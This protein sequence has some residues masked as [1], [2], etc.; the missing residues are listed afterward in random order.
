M[1]SVIT[2][3]RNFAMLLESSTKSF[4]NQHCT[5]SE[6]GKPEFCNFRA[7]LYATMRI[8]VV[9]GWKLTCDRKI[10]FPAFSSAQLHPMINEHELVEGSRELATVLWKYLLCKRHS[11]W[12]VSCE[13]SCGHDFTHCCDRL[14]P[15]AVAIHFKLIS[16]VLLSP[17]G[18]VEKWHRSRN[19]YLMSGDC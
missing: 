4:S 15:A 12:V 11:R 6:P 17:C 8:A 10:Y 9:S 13:S 3:S 5:S 1:S 7:L 18:W 16:L 2:L 14:T 19:F